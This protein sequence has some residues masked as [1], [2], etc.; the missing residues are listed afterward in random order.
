MPVPS[1]QSGPMFANKKQYTATEIRNNFIA[2]NEELKQKGYTYYQ[3]PSMQVSQIWLDGKLTTYYPDL[4]NIVYP[5]TEGPK[6]SITDYKN[7]NFDEALLRKY[8]DAKSLSDQYQDRV[9]REVRSAIANASDPS[10][11]SVATVTAQVN[12]SIDRIGGGRGI[13][14]NPNNPQYNASSLKISNELRRANAPSNKYGAPLSI[15]TDSLSIEAVRNNDADN[16]VALRKVWG[17]Q[18]APADTGLDPRSDEYQYLSYKQGE[19]Y[20]ERNSAGAY[21]SK[22]L[23]ATVAEKEAALKTAWA[24]FKAVNDELKAKGYSYYEVSDGVYG[25]VIARN[26]SKFY[27]ESLKKNRRP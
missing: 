20:K 17:A 15:N 6:G 25:T 7:P 11:V 13:T 4:P 10:K 23:A 19:N 26:D 27:V 21:K 16:I 8:T 1:N 9:S 5:S 18:P 2:V 12:S 14:L 22:T 24:D 3:L